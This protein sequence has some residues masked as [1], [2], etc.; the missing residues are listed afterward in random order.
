ML[1]LVADRCR[2]ASRPLPRTHARHRAGALVASRVGLCDVNSVPSRPE[3]AAAPPLR[4][5]PRGATGNSLSPRGRA[6]TPLRGGARRGHG[7]RHTPARLGFVRALPRPCHGL[8]PLP[9]PVAE[10]WSGG[11]RLSDPA[12]RAAR[13]TA[14]AAHTPRP[15]TPRGRRRPGP[16]TLTDTTRHLWRP[17]GRRRGGS[18]ARP[19]LSALPA[20]TY[21]P[22]AVGLL[23]A[24]AAAGAPSRPWLVLTAAAV[25]A[26][27]R[28]IY[29]PDELLL[30]RASH[31]LS[32]AKTTT[33][34]VGRAAPRTV[35]FHG[36]PG[37]FLRCR[38][39]C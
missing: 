6:C 32:A 37:Q 30:R 27:R 11:S 5:V 21:L 15:R 35:F 25:A 23:G 10:C 2:Q 16:L 39:N 14:T 4:C 33:R 29:H 26:P 28:Q 1:T 34:I 22:D 13:R 18:L 8:L 31:D 12:T 9:R 3:A 20:G 24:H 38:D 7:R 17:G 36:L 19:S